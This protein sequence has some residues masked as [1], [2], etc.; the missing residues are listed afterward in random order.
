MIQ[1]KTRALPKRSAGDCALTDRLRLKH[2]L[3]QNRV[4]TLERIASNAAGLCVNQAYV[5][6]LAISDS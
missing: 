6:I 5:F 2:Y 4:Y 1:S 3:T